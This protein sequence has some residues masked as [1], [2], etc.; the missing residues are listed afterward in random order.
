MSFAKGKC[1]ILLLLGESHVLSIGD[2]E[3]KAVNGMKDL[4]VLVSS[5]LSWSAHVKT[6]ILK[7]NGLF[8]II[9]RS[10]AP[11][12]DTSVKL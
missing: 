6:R 2:S 8:Q 11:S 12:A 1:Y 5:Y 10:I 3:P 7:A 9:R 4:G